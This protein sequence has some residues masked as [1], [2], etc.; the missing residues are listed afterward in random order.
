MRKGR[1]QTRMRR[2]LVVSGAAVA[3]GAAHRAQWLQVDVRGLLR[4]AVALG[5]TRAPLLCARHRRL[6]PPHRPQICHVQATTAAG[7]GLRE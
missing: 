1:H 7:D 4:A 5:K 2:L 3:T 6:L